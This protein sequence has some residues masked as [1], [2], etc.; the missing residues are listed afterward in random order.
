MV[1]LIDRRKTE[2]RKTDTE[3]LSR[4]AELY[5]LRQQLQTT[6]LFNSLNSIDAL[7]AINPKQARKWY[8]NCPIFAGN[9]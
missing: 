6:F 1:Q 7:I 3:K 8:S 2:K 4:D 9:A 5:K